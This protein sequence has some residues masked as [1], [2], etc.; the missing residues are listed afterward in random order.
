[1]KIMFICTGNICRS[2]MAEA[3]L[4]KKASDKDL[5]IEVYSAGTYAENGD[6]PTSSAINVMEKRGIDLKGH[7]ATNLRNSKIAEMDLILCATN[8]HKMQTIM[9]YPNLKDKIYTV[10]EYVYGTNEDIPDPWGYGEEVYE[11][12]AKELEKDIDK[13]IEKYEGNEN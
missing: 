11:R 12:C 5:N 3:I 2:A 10:K 8:S 7:R 6:V 9:L 13:L 4:K 1:M